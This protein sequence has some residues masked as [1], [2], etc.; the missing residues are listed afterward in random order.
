MVKAE[1]RVRTNSFRDGKSHRSGAK[2]RNRETSAGT[3]KNDL[4]TKYRAILQ[5]S[6]AKDKNSPSCVVPYFR[7]HA[8]KQIP[9][10]QKHLVEMPGHVGDLVSEYGSPVQRKRS[11]REANACFPGK[12]MS[13]WKEHECQ[14]SQHK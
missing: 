4:R 7:G 5:G 13:K 1:A 2:N 14:V 11:D 6:T 12:G 3:A 8:A 10:E 9:D